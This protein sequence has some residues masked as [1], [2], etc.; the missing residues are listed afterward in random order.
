MLVKDIDIPHFEETVQ[1]Y[2]VYQ[3]KESRRNSA[4]EERNRRRKT[5]MDLERPELSDYKLEKLDSAV[6]VD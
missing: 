5:M 4:R 3:A 6:V 2:R 1:E